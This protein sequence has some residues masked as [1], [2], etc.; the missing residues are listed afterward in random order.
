MYSALIYLCVCF[1]QFAR[2]FY[3]AQWFRDITSEA[4]KAMKSQSEDDEDLKGHHHSRD[5][6]LTAEIMQKAE[7]RKKFLRK[8][9]K[10]STSH[11]SSLR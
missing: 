9:V 3:I 11:F 10:T 8:A 5:V 2:K 7:G 6:D 4:E 1:I